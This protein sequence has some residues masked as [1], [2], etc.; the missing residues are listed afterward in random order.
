MRYQ[1]HA[2]KLDRC[3]SAVL[4][5]V[6]DAMGL[7]IQCLDQSIRPLEPTMRAWGEAVTIYLEAV[8]VTSSSQRWASVSQGT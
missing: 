5:D 1:G 2:D 6:M 4:M 7:R 3:Y 8:R